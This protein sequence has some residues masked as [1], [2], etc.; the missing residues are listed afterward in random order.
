MDDLAPK[1]LAD[2]GIEAEDFR[3]AVLEGLSRRQKELPCR[4]FYDAEGSR[5][6]EAI[7][8]LDEYYP[9]RTEAAI[10]RDRAAEM[11]KLAAQGAVM[12]EFGSGSSTKTEIL[13]EAMP[14]LRGYVAL[15]VSPSALDEACARI[16]ARFPSL[17]VESVVADFSE[18]M[19]LPP[20]CGQGPLVGFFPGSTIG[21]LA[22]DDAGML[23]RHFRATLGPGARL[24]IGVDL[25]KDV[26]RLI[27]AYDDAKGVTASFNL[28][29]LKRIN[30]ELGG[31][32]DLDSFT[33]RA[34]WNER[35][36]R[37]EMH[38]V[39]GKAQIAHVAGQAFSFAAGETIHTE[40]SHKY[41]IEGFRT[42]AASAG[43]RPLHVWTDAQA[44]FSVHAFAADR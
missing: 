10:L 28:N 25:R 34:I 7:T 38:L 40:N 29:L 31:D 41:S 20:L 21:N 22:S 17:E 43:W 16:A 1:A 30:R 2:S 33:H 44:L 3:R 32:F 5:L 19:D 36:G 15:D 27:P 26:S 4:F 37:I 39:S 13:L 42:L 12:V 23:L 14:Q 8:E 35:L 11:S 6:F 9:T 24:I 18:A